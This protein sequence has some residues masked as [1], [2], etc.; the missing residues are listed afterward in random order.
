MNKCNIFGLVPAEGGEGLYYSYTIYKGTQIDSHLHII[1]GDCDTNK[2][3]G[4]GS[5][6]AEK[7]PEAGATATIGEFAC[8]GCHCLY[9]IGV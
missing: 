7:V 3:A 6:G 9:H 2:K 1:A 8:D 4:E 5:S